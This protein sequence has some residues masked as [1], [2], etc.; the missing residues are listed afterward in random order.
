[1]AFIG[2]PLH[3]SEAI[4]AAAYDG[5]RATLRIKYKLDADAEGGTY[6]YLKVPPQVVDELLNAESHGQFVNW[7]IKPRYRYRRLG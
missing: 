5:A 3:E 7:R 6:D 2:L 1:M 4:A